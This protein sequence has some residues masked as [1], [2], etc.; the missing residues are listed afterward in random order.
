MKGLSTLALETFKESSLW[1]TADFMLEVSGKD[2][3]Q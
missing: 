3:K 1:N 2:K